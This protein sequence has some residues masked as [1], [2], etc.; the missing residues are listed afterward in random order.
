MDAFMTRIISLFILFFAFNSVA[1]IRSFELQN[2]HLNFADQSGRA[3]ADLFN[4]TFDF[5]ILNL[6]GYDIDITKGDGHLYFAKDD[7]NFRLQG[8]DQS[9]LDAV[10]ALSARRI[11]ITGV[12]NKSL[13]LDFYEGAVSLGEEV[14]GLDELKLDCY[15][16]TRGDDTLV[17]FLIP[18]FDNGQVSIPLIRL[19]AKSAQA[20]AP[21]WLETPAAHLAPK[22]KL[23]FLVPKKIEDIKLKIVEQRFEMTLKA[24]FIFKLKLKMNGSAVLNQKKDIAEFDIQEAKIGFIN[25]KKVIVNLLSKLEV[26]NV[27][28]E[29]SKIT[30][31]L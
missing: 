10:N 23:N 24:R 14:H 8:I 12:A 11:D 1:G 28:V 13:K 26:T 25:V 2:M 9:V 21:L 27:T 5:G 3:S 18:C 6:N 17:S 20:L 30:I 15:T 19:S 16:N 4:L 29:G 22:D 7:T 31:R